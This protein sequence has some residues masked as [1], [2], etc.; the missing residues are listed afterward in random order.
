MLEILTTRGGGEEGSRAGDSYCHPPL[1][2]KARMLDPPTTTTTPPIV[3]GKVAWRGSVGQKLAFTPPKNQ[4]QHLHCV[5][6]KTFFFLFVVLSDM[7]ILT[8]GYK[9]LVIIS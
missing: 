2:G 9:A 1:G 7:Y 5:I 3:G 8:P 4:Q 6:K